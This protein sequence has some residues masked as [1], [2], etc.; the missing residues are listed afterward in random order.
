ME[1]KYWKGLDELSNDA[2]FVRLKNNEFYEHLPID[3]VISNKAADSGA[4]PAGIFLSF[5]AL[6]L[7]RLPLHP[8]KLL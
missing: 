5:L 1:K 6:V 4:H 3:E 8:A 2:E 7:P